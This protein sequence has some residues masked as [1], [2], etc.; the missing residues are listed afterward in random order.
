MDKDLINMLVKQAKACHNSFDGI[1]SI[2][3]TLND[4]EFLYFCTECG[5]VIFTTIVLAEKLI[6]IRPN[7]IKVFV[8]QFYK[9]TR[10]YLDNSMVQIHRNKELLG[11]EKYE[12]NK[13]LVK[14]SF[15]QIENVYN[16]YM[17]LINNKNN[18]KI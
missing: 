5:P 10:N 9:D 13:K 3:D 18:E 11:E 6:N 12:H 14:N 2:L 16:I 4:E 17:V 7:V 1:E 15:K 8:N